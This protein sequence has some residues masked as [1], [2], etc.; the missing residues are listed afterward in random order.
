MRI[1]ISILLAFS[2]FSCFGQLEE[3]DRNK[4]I[5]YSKE[6]MFGGGLHTMGWNVNFT[7]GKMKKYTVTRIFTFDFQEI[8][9]PKEKR[10]TA[11]N[12]RTYLYGKQN[13][14]YQFKVG[15][16]EKRYFSEKQ[17]RKGIAVGMAYAFGPQIGLAKPYYLDF[18]SQTGVQSIK[19][20]EEDASLFLSSSLTLGASG[21]GVGW[22]E[23]KPYPGGFAKLA[24]LLD[25][26]AFDEFAKSLE[27]GVMVD[28]YGANIPIMAQGGNYPVFFNMYVNLNLGRR[29]Y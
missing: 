11:Y 27:I 3:G 16:G 14:F 15:Y 22:G 28:A 8:N 2:G 6:F 13:N 17:K 26:G 19:Y 4:G 5:I 7:Y 29:V 18:P 24:L 1:F 10:L 21:P 25:W 20:S 12:G 23:I 9:H